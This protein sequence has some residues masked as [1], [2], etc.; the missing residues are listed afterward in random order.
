MCSP[1]NV[2]A[3]GTASAAGVKP[4]ITPKRGASR[5]RKLWEV[6]HELHCSIVGTCF[7]VAELRT[8]GRKAGYPLSP[9]RSDYEVHGLFSEA[10]RGRC[11]LSKFM[12]KALDAKYAAAIRRFSRART[13][14]EVAELWAQ[15]WSNQDVPGAYWAT[16]THPQVTNRLVEQAFGEVHMLSHLSGHSKLVEAKRFDELSEQDL[17]LCSFSQSL[18]SKNFQNIRKRFNESWVDCL[19][20]MDTAFTNAAV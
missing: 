15:A 2:A 4:A 3:K 5:R 16:V 11:I 20:A 1:I 17:L 10:A 14:T 9:N 18:Q 13:D 7:S 6:R 8:I 19:I 12:Q